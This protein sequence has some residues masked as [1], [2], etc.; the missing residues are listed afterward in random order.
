M[1]SRKKMA[2]RRVATTTNAKDV[3]IEENVVDLTTPPE[4]EPIDLT[5]PSVENSVDMT[6][7]LTNKEKLIAIL[8]ATLAR[9]E[10]HGK[11]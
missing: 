10:N 3:E 4:D 11:R 2:T 9:A 6:V 5:M 7:S 1:V 8:K